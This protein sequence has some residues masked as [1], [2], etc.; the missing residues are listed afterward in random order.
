MVVFMSLIKELNSLIAEYGLTP[1]RKLSQHFL[2]DE[3]AIQSMIETSELTEK[4]IVLEIGAG[5][6]FL[7]REL[8]SKAGKV[9]AV[10]LD[11]RL[12]AL[13]AS[14]L[15]K[16]KLELLKGDY[17]ALKMPAYNKVVASPPYNISTKMMYKLFKEKFDL[18]VLLLQ[19]EFVERITAEPGFYDY[20]ALSVATQYFTEPKVLQVIRPESF[21]PR[22]EA[23]SVLVK[24]VWKK[25]FGKAVKEEK[26]IRFI[27]EIFRYKN[28]NLSNALQLSFPFLK[29]EFKLSIEKQDF[30]KMLA[31]LPE[32]LLTQ[33]LSFIE[34]KDLVAV[35]NQ[36]V[37]RIN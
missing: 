5:T 18:A 7:T 21:Y 24:L 22:P 12:H 14:K 1:S 3:K 17:L 35:W 30:R 6:G 23:S 32:E 20:N 2:V 16:E 37:K 31:G 34:I 33:K 10:E 26:F 19:G 8:L 13:L 9:I 25:R 11:E 4:D 27:Q 15:P 29:K 28:K 36:L